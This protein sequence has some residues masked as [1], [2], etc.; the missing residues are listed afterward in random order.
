MVLVQQMNS[1]K[2]RLATEN[3]GSEQCCDPYL[4]SKPGLRVPQRMPKCIAAIKGSCPQVGWTISQYC[5]ACHGLP[6]C[7]FH[8][9]HLQTSTWTCL[10]L[11]CAQFNDKQACHLHEVM[12]RKWVARGKRTQDLIRLFEGLSKGTPKPVKVCF[13]TEEAQQ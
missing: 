6:G 4:H 10:S 2:P 7:I 5:E 8:P 12:M 9:A 3:I 11:N 13:L 1:K